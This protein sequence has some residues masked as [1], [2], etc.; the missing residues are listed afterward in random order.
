VYNRN[1]APAPFTTDFAIDNTVFYA[2]NGALRVKTTGQEASSAYKM[3]AVPAP[4]AQFWVRVYI[5][6]DAELG[7]GTV[8][9]SEHNRFLIAASGSEANTTDALEVAEDC[10]IA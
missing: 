4:S 2:G 1:G 7:Q 9:S 5:R 6:A 8:S 10:G 3:L